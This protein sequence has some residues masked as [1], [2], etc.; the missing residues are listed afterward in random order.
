MFG[1]FK[2]KTEAEKLNKKYDKLMQEGY[3]LSTINRKASD[4]K[5]AE[6]DRVLKQIEK[7]SKTQS[8]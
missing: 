3:E 6:A 1:L 8:S 7:L 2:R 5:Y 4:A